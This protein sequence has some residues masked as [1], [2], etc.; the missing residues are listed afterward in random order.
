MANI[1]VSELKE[2]KNK[3][4]E[5]VR[6]F[7]FNDLEVEITQHLPITKKIE[8]AT[9]VFNGCVDSDNGLF[10]V[11]HTSK[12]I[13]MAYFITQYYTNINLPKDIIEGYD[14]LVSTGLYDFIIENF[15]DEEWFEV[16]DVISN[17]I[18]TELKKHKQQN[19]TQYILKNTLSTIINKIPT[20]EEVKK[21]IE[22]AGKEI[23]GFDK[24]KLNFVGDFQKWNHGVEANGDKEV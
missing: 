8:L 17:K 2:L 13:M 19:S 21:F 3:I 11:N 7:S 18:M 1:K 23:D 15:K 12:H 16:E 20:T 10:V 5:D 24:K 14:L 22:E 9:L 4:V 6:T